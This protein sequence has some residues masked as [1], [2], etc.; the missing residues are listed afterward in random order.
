M[1]TM[2]TLLSAFIILLAFSNIGYS[3]ENEKLFAMIYSKGNAWN[4]NIATSEQAYFKAH[5]RHLQRLRKQG[6]ILMGGRYSN[7]GF[8]ILK[9]EDAEKAEMI[10]KQDS[11][12]VGGTFKVELFEFHPFYSGCIGTTK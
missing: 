11:S 1:L 10:T 9:A 6:K 3:Q 7:L 4:E 5:T 2:R 8:M 12:V